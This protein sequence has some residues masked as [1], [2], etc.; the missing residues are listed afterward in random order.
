VIWKKLCEFYLI[1]LC[2]IES[3]EKNWKHRLGK[4]NKVECRNLHILPSK[5]DDLSKYILMKRH[6]KISEGNRKFEKRN[7]LKN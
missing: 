7:F 1:K 4:S 5:F 6:L 2:E 3:C